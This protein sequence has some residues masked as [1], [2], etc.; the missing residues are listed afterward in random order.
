MEL[1]E[2]KM[3]EGKCE[4]TDYDA[5][6]IVSWSELGSPLLPNDT[7]TKGLGLASENFN[8]SRPVVIHDKPRR[9]GGCPAI[10][11]FCGT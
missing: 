3:V 8:P 9:V 7:R 6:V 1:N 10:Q 4:V 11:L 5:R 2:E